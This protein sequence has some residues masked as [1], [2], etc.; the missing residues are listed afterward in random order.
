MSNLKLPNKFIELSQ[1]KVINKSDFYLYLL[2]RNNKVVYVGQSSNIFN[3]IGQHTDSEKQFDSVFVR[4]LRSKNNFLE[5]YMIFK[6]HSQYNKNIPT[7]SRFINFSYF[8][9]TQPKVNNCKLEGKLIGGILYIDKRKFSNL[10]LK[11]MKERIPIS[12]E[13]RECILKMELA[14][15]EYYKNK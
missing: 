4:V 7:N 11:E 14:N 9:L 10:N 1:L 12:T 5:A 13:E 2:V 6:H 3:R 15:I 8:N